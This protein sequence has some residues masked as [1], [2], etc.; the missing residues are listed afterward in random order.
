M[1]S[2]ISFLENLLLML[3]SEN[4]NGII[5]MLLYILFCWPF[6]FPFHYRVDQLTGQLQGSCLFLEQQLDGR[7]RIPRFFS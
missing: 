5:R 3:C 7:L 2:A 6:D 1:H 4:K